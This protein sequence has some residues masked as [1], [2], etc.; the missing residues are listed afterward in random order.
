VMDQWSGVAGLL[1]KEEPPKKI[2][3]RA[4]LKFLEGDARFAGAVEAF[5]SA[6]GCLQKGQT[7]NGRNSRLMK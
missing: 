7:K 6:R 3:R 5:G 4:G 2:Q 1:D